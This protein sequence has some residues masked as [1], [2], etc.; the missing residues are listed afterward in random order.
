MLQVLIPDCSEA[1]KNIEESASYLHNDFGQIIT[2]IMGHPFVMVNFV[3][4]FPKS[5]I[6]LLGSSDKILKSTLLYT[7]RMHSLKSEDIRLLIKF[8]SAL[9]RGMNLSLP[10][11]EYDPLNYEEI[12]PDTI[13]KSDKEEEDEAKFKVKKTKTPR[14][15]FIEF[16]LNKLVRDKVGVDLILP[17]FMSNVSPLSSTSDKKIYG[18]NFSELMYDEESGAIVRELFGYPLSKS[19]MKKVRNCIF[20]NHNDARPSMDVILMPLVWRNSAKMV[21]FVS[22]EQDQALEEMYRGEITTIVEKKANNAAVINNRTV[23]TYLCKARC[24]STKCAFSSV[25]TNM[26]I[27]QLK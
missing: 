27:K 14:Y 12:F 13:K 18:V 11:S 25:L 5:K 20:P 22:R 8:A 19:E 16:D 7:K 1:K 24:Y 21:N 17:Q 15:I 3:D 26:Q 4:R 10:S 9:A 23:I 6:L 2:P